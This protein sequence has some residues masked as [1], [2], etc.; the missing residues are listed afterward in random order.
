[1]ETDELPYIS[2]I[3]TA[4]DRKEFLLN[5]IK[6]VVNQTLDKKYYEIIVIKNFRDENIDDFINENKIK[7][8]L[9][10]GTVGEFLYKGI[11]EA[12]GEIIS[13]LDDDDLFS[14]NNLEVIYNKFKSNNDLCYYHDGHIVVNEKY[15]KLIKKIGNAISFNMSSISVRKSILNLNYIKK[16]SSNTDHFMYLSALEANK[17][18]V[19]GKKT[20]TYYMYHSSSSRLIGNDINQ[21]IT[22]K[23]RILEKD[24]KQFKMFSGMFSAKKSIDYI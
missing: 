16:I 23:K 2:V 12:N 22:Y 21:I 9:M 10:D 13:F 17:D 7:H 3:I 11:S 14:S 15:Q 8:K 1:M 20:L 18:I 6:S 5:A 4:Y 24:L 19:N